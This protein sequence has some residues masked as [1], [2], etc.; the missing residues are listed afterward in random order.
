MRTRV[1]ALKD[2]SSG[3]LLQQAWRARQAYLFL[4]PLLISIVVFNY[5]PPVSGMYHAFFD[6]NLSGKEEFIGLA[7]FREIFRDQVFLDSIPTLVILTIPRLL[8]G[9]IVPLIMAEMIFAVKSSRLK[10]GYRVLILLPM[11]IPGVVGTLIWKFVFDPSQGLITNLARMVGAIG[12]NRVID[13]L[14][15]PDTVIPS[16]IFM[17]FPWIGGTA[18]LIYM[19][20]LL[21]IS[22]EVIESSVIDG[23]GVFRRIWKI[24]LPLLMGQIRFF[25]ITGLIGLIQ[26]FGLQLIITNGGPGYSTYVPAYHLY[27]MAFQS[28]RMGYASAIGVV[29]FVFI[30]ALSL[31]AHKFLKNNK[32]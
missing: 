1:Q 14:G 5:Y 27:M 19:A 12:D 10:Y 17:G 25:V 32:T 23:C 28:G 8:I 9:V 26:D 31:A 29:M 6:W 16:V 11:V 18:V 22:G 21:T 2:G 7:N 30:F 3:S 24:D 13:W 15:N 20:G 4:L